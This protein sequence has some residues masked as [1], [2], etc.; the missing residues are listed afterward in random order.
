MQGESAGV[1]EGAF[2]DV[3]SVLLTPLPLPPLPPP[4]HQHE[5]KLSN[6][7]N[8]T[9]SP[10]TYYN[11]YDAE[12]KVRKYTGVTHLSASDVNLDVPSFTEDTR[13]FVEG[14]HNGETEV[15]YD[16]KAVTATKFKWRK[17]PSTTATVTLSATYHTAYP[18]LDS[19]GAEYLFSTSP[20]YLDNGVYVKWATLSKSSSDQWTFKAFTFW[21]DSYD[22]ATS[23]T[24]AAAGSTTSGD[25]A[26]IFIEGTYINT[27]S[28]TYRLQVSVDTTM[29]R[30]IKWPY[31][32]DV[33]ELAKLSLSEVTLL[34]C[35]TCLG[36]SVGYTTSCGAVST[37]LCWSDDIALSDKVGLA[38]LTAIDSG[39]KVRWATITAGSKSTDDYWQFT[40]YRRH[41][42]TYYGASYI[43]AATLSGAK[44]L[45]DPRTPTAMGTYSGNETATFT[46][47]ISGYSDSCS[48][49]C[50]HFVWRKE[51]A[52]YNGTYQSSVA[53][54][55]NARYDYVIQSA[56]MRL[57]D[58]V[59]VVFGVTSGYQVNNEYFFVAKPMPSSILNVTPRFADADTI[60]LSSLGTYHEA[61]DA[62]F[63][64]W[65][66]RPGSITNLNYKTG[67]VR[68]TKPQ[69]VW[70]R[71]VDSSGDSV[72]TV[73]ITSAGTSTSVPGN[74][75]WRKVRPSPPL[76]SALF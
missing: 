25:N 19:A 73:E 51:T 61:G 34:T 6:R 20:V 55:P 5:I 27:T 40:A 75:K 48:S 4:L 53:R 18:T 9:F 62:P 74:F 70:R 54:P 35:T 1:R 11:W 36:M 50:T 33:P 57:S 16:I 29:F 44:T 52:T 43:S 32:S 31:G 38:K 58:G 66:P 46:V 2:W 22:I 76:P 71:T 8:Y 72:F 69:G 56:P 15:T 59:F 26:K 64:D 47:K 42:I 41:F 65:L 7:G 14:Y 49:S 24:P 12:T 10:S 21:S 60:T 28:Y 13:L 37:A 67:S 3:W 68:A 39:I 17:Y 45:G 30:W 63:G 23:F